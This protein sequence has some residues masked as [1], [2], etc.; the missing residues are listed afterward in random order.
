MTSQLSSPALTPFLIPG[1][2]FSRSKVSQVSHN[3]TLRVSDG[4]T[5]HHADPEPKSIALPLHFR[6]AQFSLRNGSLSSRLSLHPRYPTA[7]GFPCLQSFPSSSHIMPSY[8]FTLCRSK[9]Q[10]PPLIFKTPL[11]LDSASLAYLLSHC[12]SPRLLC[13]SHTVAPFLKN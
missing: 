11:S 5:H 1:L 8:F 4:Q 9:S 2:Q 10:C 13:S 3:P 6:S 12:L 7:W